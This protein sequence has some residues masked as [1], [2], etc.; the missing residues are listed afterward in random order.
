[1]AKMEDRSPLIIPKENLFVKIILFIW[2]LPQ[3][4]IGFIFYLLLKKYIRKGNIYYFFD[5]YNK[6]ES[7][8]PYMYIGEDYKYKEYIVVEKEKF[9]SVSLGNFVFIKKPFE[10]FTVLHEYGHQKQSKKLGIF[11]LIFIGLPSIICNIYDR[12]FHKKW[13]KEK[14]IRWYYN[15]LWEKNANKLSNLEYSSN[16]T[17]KF[18]K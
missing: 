14:R 18:I 11:Y 3:N 12:I 8:N 13:T 5:L 16:N 7:K 10:L 15:L 2:Q 17:F 9:N 1:M 4:I 6:Q